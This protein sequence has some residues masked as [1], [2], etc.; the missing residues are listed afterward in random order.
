ML[1]QLKIPVYNIEIGLPSIL[2][3]TLNHNF[4]IL[5]CLISLHLILIPLL[6]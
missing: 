1:R 3:G 6:G 4:H 2:K 5:I